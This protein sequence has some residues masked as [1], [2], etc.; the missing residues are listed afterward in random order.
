MFAVASDFMQGCG[1]C[2]RALCERRDKAELDSRLR[3]GKASLG[4][5]GHGL[6]VRQAKI[7]AD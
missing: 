7:N 1:S 2:L 5:I 3:G 4:Q 6:S